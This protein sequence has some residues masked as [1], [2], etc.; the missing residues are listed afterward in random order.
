MSSRQEI[1]LKLESIKKIRF[2]VVKGINEFF[3]K[4]SFS[5]RMSP[6][7]RMIWSQSVSIMDGEQL[8][9]LIDM[10]L[11][12]AGLGFVSGVID[13]AIAIGSLISII[14]NLFG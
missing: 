4:D 5:T 7:D 6:G 1:R 10:T 3:Q 13:T 2:V 9:L 8:H 11:A 12:G 14:S